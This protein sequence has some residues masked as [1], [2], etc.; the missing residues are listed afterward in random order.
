MSNCR[1]MA[2]AYSACSGSEHPCDTSLC[3]LRG[4]LRDSAV[5]KLLQRIQ[6]PRTL[7]YTESIAVSSGA[8]GIQIWSAFALSWHVSK[9]SEVPFAHLCTLHAPYRCRTPST[10]GILSPLPSCTH[11]ALLCS[12]PV[13]LSPG[14]CPC[15][16]RRAGSRWAQVSCSGLCPA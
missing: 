11:L 6:R 12:P 2:T 13:L 9:E 1:C 4:D 15:S 7:F 8:Q 16:C 10:W 3:C 14:R 5:H